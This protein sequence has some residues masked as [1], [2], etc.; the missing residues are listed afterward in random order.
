MIEPRP[1][2]SIP[3]A[4][5]AQLPH[6]LN[7]VLLICAFAY[8]FATFA[9]LPDRF[10]I[11]YDMSGKPDGW[12]EKSMP[13]WLLFPLLALGMTVLF[14][15]LGLLVNYFKKHPRLI[16]IPHKQKFLALLPELQEPVWQRVR[17]MLYWMA[18]PMNAMFIFIMHFI[19]SQATGKYQIDF[20]WGLIA[21]M[22]LFL[23]VIIGSFISMLRA[24]KE[25]TSLASMR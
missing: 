16:N 7:A 25:A 12:A 1:P 9:D 22:V 15:T 13:F 21:L 23:A 24:I 17:A 14:Y 19:Y 20:W 6:L 8:A 4:R 2:T 5:F 3:K 10:P 11:H 18:V